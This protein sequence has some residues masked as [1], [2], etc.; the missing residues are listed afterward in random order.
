MKLLDTLDEIKKKKKFD[1]KDRIKMYL[2]H[3]KN[4]SP[5]NFKVDSDDDKIIISIP[6]D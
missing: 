1:H 2:K 3:Y 5:K 6:K 4:L